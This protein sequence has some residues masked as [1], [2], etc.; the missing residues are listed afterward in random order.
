MSPIESL[1]STFVET[2]IA[3]F[4]A[5]TMETVIG[6]P[7]NHSTLTLKLLAVIIPAFT[8]LSTTSSI[9]INLSFSNRRLLPQKYEG[10][11]HQF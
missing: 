3:G 10:V 7:L 2:S 11:K 5:F 8:K 9:S 1:A 4:P 6:I